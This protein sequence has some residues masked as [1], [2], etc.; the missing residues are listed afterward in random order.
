M[1]IRSTMAQDIAAVKAMESAPEAVPWVYQWTEDQHRAALQ[2]PD[3][4]HWMIENDAGET[5]GYCIMKGLQNPFGVVELM[6]IVIGPKRQGFGREA[7]AAIIMKVFAELKARRLWLDVVDTN[8]CAIRLYEDLGFA[9][10]GTLR[11]S[12]LI[13]GHPVSMRI[14][15]LLEREWVFKMM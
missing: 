14:Y 7:M 10:E 3:T 13:Q 8:S 2:D 11:E 15:G 1:K 6:R 9:H 4:G 12:A 5:V